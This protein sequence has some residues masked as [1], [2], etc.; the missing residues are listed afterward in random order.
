[1]NS[2]GEACDVFKTIH[3]AESRLK[4]K[5][6]TRVQCAPNLTDSWL[7]AVD[8]R[9]LVTEYHCWL[10]EPVSQLMAVNLRLWDVKTLAVS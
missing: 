4:K 7:V 2:L 10:R 8:Y 1:M 3:P 5:K 6:Q 9:F